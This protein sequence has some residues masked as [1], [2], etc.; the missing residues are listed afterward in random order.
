MQSVR[1]F[2]AVAMLGAAVAAIYATSRLEAVAPDLRQAA[3]PAPAPA[4][5][6]SEGDMEFTVFLSGNQ[7]GV[8]HTRVARTGT[9]WVISSTAQF[10]APLSMTVNRFEVKYTAD[11]QPTELHIDATQ[12]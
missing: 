2:T 11:W 1:H 10:S 9:T 6:P 8:E 7:V 4:P 3:G 5:A 12:A